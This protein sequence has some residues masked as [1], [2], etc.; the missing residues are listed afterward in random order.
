MPHTVQVLIIYLNQV[1]R[2]GRGLYT[3]DILAPLIA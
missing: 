1:T 2:A 3:L